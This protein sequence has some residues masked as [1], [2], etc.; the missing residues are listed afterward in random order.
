MKDDDVF[1]TTEPLRILGVDGAHLHC[2]QDG[3]PLDASEQLE[4]EE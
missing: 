4:R 1:P 3:G 2:T